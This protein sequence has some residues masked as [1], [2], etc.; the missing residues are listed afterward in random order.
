VLVCLLLFMDIPFALAVA[1]GIPVSFA[2][3]LVT[4][5]FT[6]ATL[7]MISLLGL[8]MATG[9]IVDDAI[10]ISDSVWSFRRQGLAPDLAAVKGTLHVASPVLMASATTIVTFVPLMYVEG[11]MGKL[12]YVLPVTV[13]A[14]IVASALEAFAILPAHLC[15][16]PGLLKS[17]ARP[18]MIR[19]VREG[20]DRW[21]DRF[22]YG[23]FAR[24]LR[25]CLHRRAVVLG[26]AL[27]A[28]SICVGLVLGGRA[29]FV[30]FPAVDSN[31]VRARVQFPDG[32]PI[33]VS[34]AAVDRIEAAARG[35][36]E[37]PDLKPKSPGN[38]VA[39]IYSDVGEW[40]DYVPKRSSSLCETSIELMRAEERR[41]DVAK[42]I[43][44]WREG[45]GDIPGAVSMI[46]TREQLG[47]TEGAI[48]IRLLGDNL[49]ELRLAADDV[50]A[51]LRTY[52]HVFNIGDD[53]TPGKRE[54]QVTFKP[55]ARNL[56]LTVSELASQMRQ[57]LYGGEALRLQRGADEVKV[58]VSYADRDS[59]SLAAIENLRIRTHTGAE[60]PFTEVAET[61]L[62]RSYSAITRQAGTRLCRIKA[63]IDERFANAEQII[64]SMNAKFLPELDRRYAG[65]R[66]LLD[67]QRKRIDESLR[68]LVRGACVAAV[69][70]F[71]LL[72]TILRSYLQPVIIMI[73][74]P[75]GAIGAIFGHL[76]LGYDLTLMSAFGVVALSGIVVN[77][78]LVLIDQ[79][80]RNVAEGMNIL[81]SVIDACQT[82]F[83][84]VI[85][86]TVTTVCGLLPLIAERS[87]QALPLI[88]LAIT[89][90][91]G[92][93]FGT[94]L[95]LIV[96]PAMFVIVN[97]VKR[98][99]HWLRF[100][101]DY[102]APETVEAVA[103]T[104]AMATT[105]RN[106]DAAQGG[107]T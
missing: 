38:L 67:G 31:L 72:G 62:V 10:V 3:A 84:A 28:F 103:A 49:D 93:L 39:Q 13:I 42:V 19:R 45:I 95:T 22:I 4:L 60:I 53:L 66:Y 43:E 7:N 70:M 77:D 58:M 17:S 55:S 5:G 25:Q 41:V 107:I 54:L 81:D 94:V 52:D 87:S 75:L 48:E 65:V 83:R 89:I 90:A 56:G 11:V 16:W 61:R 97:D 104:M 106:T 100:G 9:I 23:F 50:I 51:E 74:I 20:L 47:P 68:S 63:D 44:A 91:F 30:L 96:V 101:G 6:G 2:G 92:E 79:I 69:V 88:P 80:N 34:Q 40:P 59:K 37:R 8:L 26:A 24:M 36:N 73:A 1:L 33:D 105:A 14:A 102:P 27:A 15:E 57:G 71:A 86:T 32:T 29:P 35:L 64:S 98:F 99:A 82:R 18:S 21:I 46:I 12:I 78:A 85:L 76:L